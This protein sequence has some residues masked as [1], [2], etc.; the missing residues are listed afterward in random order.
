MDHFLPLRPITIRAIQRVEVQSRV[1]C[2]RCATGIGPWPTVLSPVYPDVFELITQRGFRIHG[3]ADNLQI[4]DHCSVSDIRSSKLDSP[5]ASIAFNR[6]WPV[7]DCGSMARKPSSSGSDHHVASQD[8]PSV[9]SSLVVVSSIL[10]HRSVTSGSYSTRPW[11]LRITLQNSPAS[12]STTSGSFDRFG[13]P[14]PRILVTLS[15]GHW[16]SWG[17]TTVTGSSV[18]LPRSSSPGCLACFALRRGSFSNSQ[19]RVTY[20]SRWRNSYTGS[21]FQHEWASNCAPLR[22]GASTV[23]PRPTWRNVVTAW[24]LD[25]WIWDQQL[26]RVAELWFRKATLRRFPDGH[27]PY[28][29]LWHGTVCLMSSMMTLWVLRTSEE[30]WKLFSSSFYSFCADSFDNYVTVFHC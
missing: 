9:H 10:R 23:L 5:A 1:N 4:Y 3:Y 14:L 6:G 28:H 27:L 8:V 21:T 13:A 2:M 20:R 17:L 11:V 29:T 18:A 24:S 26:L 15:S 7:I 22:S 25:D 12:H 19:E 16:L 30:N